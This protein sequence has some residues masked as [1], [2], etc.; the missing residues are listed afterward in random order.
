MQTTSIK[1]QVYIENNVL[2]LSLTFVL[3]VLS[4]MFPYAIHMAGLKGTEFLPIFFSLA[5][6]SAFLSNKK[7][8]ALAVI[9]PTTNMLLTGMPAIPIYYFLLL[10]SVAFT[11]FIILGRKFKLNFYLM[12]VLAFVLARFS[13]IV[14]LPL[15]SQININ[16]WFSG[17]VRGYKGII[18]NILLSALFFKALKSKKS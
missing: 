7:L 8:I 10:E 5:I 2:E 13:S 11:V 1:N 15:F 12:V 6:S 9:I 14:L 17:I 16:S 3:I 18:V 4:V